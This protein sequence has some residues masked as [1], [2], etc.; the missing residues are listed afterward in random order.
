MPWPNPEVPEEFTRALDIK[1]DNV[2]QKSMQKEL[3]LY[4]PVEPAPAIQDIAIPEHISENPAEP[5]AIPEN[6]FSPSDKLFAKVKEII[7]KMYIPGEITK[8]ET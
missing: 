7:L 3:P 8:T 2:I 5:Y 4:A 6:S 1:I